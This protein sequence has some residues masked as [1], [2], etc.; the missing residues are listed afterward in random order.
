MKSVVEKHLATKKR[1]IGNVEYSENIVQ[2]SF[3]EDLS[4]KLEE[5]FNWVAKE[6][7]IKSLCP[8]LIEM[9]S[10]NT[11]VSYISE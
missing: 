7:S 1:T 3:P 6:K 4:I 10:R 9:D 8:V 11:T 5:G 2:L